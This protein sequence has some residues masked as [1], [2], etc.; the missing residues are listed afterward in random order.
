MKRR[1][2]RE[3][4]AAIARAEQ[5]LRRMPEEA[6]IAAEL[7]L[8][9]DEYRQKLTEMEA[10]NVGEIEFIRDDDETSAILK[11]IAADDQE[12]PAERL[13]RSEL[14]RIIASAID[15]IPK[16]EKM[17]LSLYF[18]EE[19][20]LR[21]IAEM[22]GIHLSRVCQIKSQA[23]LRLRTAMARHWPGTRA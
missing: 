19:L 21:E 20:T 23:I 14:E 18:F 10:L 22:M 8:T 7:N 11:H 15:R 5:R 6:E 3:F 16:V 9:V 1:Q 12:S 2:A 17:V 13:E 4:E